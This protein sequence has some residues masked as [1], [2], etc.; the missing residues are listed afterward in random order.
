MLTLALLGFHG[1]VEP[2]GVPVR[3]ALHEQFGRAHDRAAAALDEV[4]DLES[5]TVVIVSAPVVMFAS[6]IQAER[7]YRGI[8]RP[9]HLYLLSDASSPT[10][11]T[12]SGPA[13]L[14]L[15]PGE[16]FLYSPLERH[17]RAT[18]LPVG[19]E[20]VLSTMTARVVAARPDGRPDRA[21]FRFDAAPG[22]YV[23]LTWKSGRFVPFTL[24][25][26][27]S[28]VLLPEEDFGDVVLRASL[29]SD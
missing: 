1:V 26:Q 17:Y 15:R 5:K 29:E 14:T 9:A 12:R 19:T 27:G 23:F 16:G 25:E 4:P 3:A 6:Y 20:T 2:L 18:P 7:E 28:P 21:A 13:E 10:E 24:P 22:S 11:V 8:S